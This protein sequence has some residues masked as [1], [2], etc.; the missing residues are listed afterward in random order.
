MRG[1][2]VLALAVLTFAG[3]SAQAA[4]EEVTLEHLGLDLTANFEAASGKQLKSEPVVLLVHDSLGH[5]RNGESAVCVHW[6]LRAEPDGGGDSA[7]LRLGRHQG[8]E[9]G[10]SSAG[11]HR[12]DSAKGAG[13]PR[14]H[15][16]RTVLEGVAQPRAREARR[17][18]QY[19]GDARSIAVSWAGL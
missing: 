5:G 1:L 17:D 13:E 2:R 7:V 12:P 18:R 3:L 11:I 14:D 6:E 16:R 19:V 15:A 8:G 4:A 10:R 9:C